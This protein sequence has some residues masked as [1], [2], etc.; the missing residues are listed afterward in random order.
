MSKVVIAGDASG[1]GTFTISAPNGNT[2]RTLVLPDEAGTIITTAG[3]PASAM[4]AGSVLQVVS[5]GTTAV[6]STS[7]T[8]YVATSITATIT[9]TSSSNKIYI[10]FSGS[11]CTT[12]ANTEVQVTV[13]R[14]GTNLSATSLANLYTATHSGYLCVSLPFQYLDS[15]AT[16]SATT[17]TVYMKEAGVPGTVQTTGEVKTITLME[18]AA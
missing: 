14:N 9:P 10:V 1:T 15:P 13:Y 7:S 18:I 3:V 16:T 5:A 2:D 12:A 4:P 8:T 6:T 17:Y 11:F